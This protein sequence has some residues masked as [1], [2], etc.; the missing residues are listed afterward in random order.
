MPAARPTVMRPATSTSLPG[1]HAISSPPSTKQADESTSVR[2]RP[3]QSQSFPEQ[4][5]P[6]TAPIVVEDAISPVTAGRAASPNSLLMPRSAPA[7]TPVLKPWSSEPS[8]A[9]AATCS[10]ARLRLLG[11]TIAV[12]ALRPADGSAA[13]VWSARR[14]TPT[15]MSSVGRFMIFGNYAGSTLRC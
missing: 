15:L 8:A 12:V 14:R 2:F 10:P 1:D 3:T 4:A 7:I 11:T 13:S 6:T 9:P 5:V